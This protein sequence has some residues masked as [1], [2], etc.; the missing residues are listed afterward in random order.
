[1]A[2][3]LQNFSTS[4]SNN[5]LAGNENNQG[6]EVMRQKGPNDRLLLTDKLSKMRN[7]EL[8]QCRDI[9]IQSD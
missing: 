2:A 4:T 6:C 5:V 1:M 8:T 7:V 3:P 9:S